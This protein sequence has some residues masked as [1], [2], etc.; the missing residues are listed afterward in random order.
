LTYCFLINEKN[1]Q[2]YA[3]ENISK[4][5]YFEFK[6][7]LL[8]LLRKINKENFELI[9]GPNMVVQAD[10]TVIIRERLVINP[11]GE[12]DE[13]PGSTWLVGKIECT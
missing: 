4:K 6:R 10:E 8:P 9:G 2:I 7:K 5:S 1:V 12:R 11:S 13:L 3:L